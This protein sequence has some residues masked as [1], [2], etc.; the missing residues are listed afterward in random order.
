MTKTKWGVFILSWLVG[1]ALYGNSVTGETMASEFTK[2]DEK[3]DT[4]KVVVR[5][6]KTCFDKECDAWGP[7]T[8]EEWITYYFGSQAKVA[9]AV[10]KCESNLH[11][12]RVH[13]DYREHSVGLF[14]I[15]LAKDSGLGTKVH[16]N[17]VPGNTLEA[18]TK[19]LQVPENNVGIAKEIYNAS[20]WYPWTCF[21]NG[22]YQKYL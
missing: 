14:Q 21:T 7:Q 8:I 13:S 9:L 22:G 19:W 20:G 6:I 18:K 15:N 11:P 3:P 10:A 5:S 1:L 4:N 12:D 16:W 2:I 17:K